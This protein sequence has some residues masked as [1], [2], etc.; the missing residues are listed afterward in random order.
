[1]PR[2][3]T[4]WR[5]LTAAAVSL[6]WSLGSTPVSAADVYRLTGDNTRITISVRTFGLTWLSARFNDLSGELVP[7]RRVQPSR[8][9]VTIDTASLS[10]DSP[11]WRARLL[12]PAWFDAQQYPRISYHSARVVFGRDGGGTVSGRLTLHGQTHPLDLTVN[13][14]DCA[15]R[16]GAAD[17]CSFDA[18]GSIR[19]SEYGLPHGILEAGDEVVIDIRGDAIRAAT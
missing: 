3:F 18:E 9:D 10:C 4:T 16:P 13:R 7:E 12:S 15:N 8:V 5:K 1:M 19:R 6:L 14:W 17:T 2:W 11:R